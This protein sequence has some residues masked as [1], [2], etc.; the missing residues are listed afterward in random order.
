VPVQ[1]GNSLGFVCSCRAET[2]PAHKT[3]VKEIASDAFLMASMFMII[4]FLI[5]KS[6]PQPLLQHGCTGNGMRRT[7]RVARLH[8]NDADAACF[9]RLGSAAAAA[10]TGKS[11]GICPQLPSRNRPGAQN[12][13]NDH[14]QERIFYCFLAHDSPS[15]LMKGIKIVL[16]ANVTAWLQ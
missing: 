9:A 1:A 2:L 6:K 4:S 12:S 7:K 3:A 16:S 10:A 14:G 13:R 11:F 15:F 8:Q 5:G